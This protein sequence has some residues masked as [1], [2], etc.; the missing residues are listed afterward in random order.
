MSLYRFVLVVAIVVLVA[1]Y[2]PVAHADLVLKTDTKSNIQLKSKAPNVPGDLKKSL[3]GIAKV[4]KA[5]KFDVAG[6]KKELVTK[7]LKFDFKPK[8]SLGNLKLKSLTKTGKFVLKN[9]PVEV[10]KNLDLKY[11]KKN[12]DVGQT[13][14]RKTASFGAS[15]LLGLDVTNSGL[16][17]GF[18]L[19]WLPNGPPVPSDPATGLSFLGLSAR[20]IPEPST[21]LLLASGLLGLTILTRKRVTSKTT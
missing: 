7:S 16:I 20:T 14:K 15:L 13:G 5:R 4:D 8:T 3:T 6:K 18:T 2:V 11:L 19:D 1:S 10:F 9:K 17:S 12:D 21:L